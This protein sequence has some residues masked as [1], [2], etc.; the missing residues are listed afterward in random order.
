MS[1]KTRCETRE[2]D[3][4]VAQY[5]RIYPKGVSCPMNFKCHWNS[6]EYAV[7]KKCKIV[8]CY[9]VDFTNTGMYAHFINVDKDGNYIET[10][11][12]ST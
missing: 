5:K 9:V 6:L 11:V 8:S 4:V 7:N 2:R 10:S 1:Y 3:Y 12:G